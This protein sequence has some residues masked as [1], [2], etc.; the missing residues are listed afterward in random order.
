MDLKLRPFVEDFAL[1]RA[2]ALQVRGEI[3]SGRYEVVIDDRRVQLLVHSVHTDSEG[4]FALLPSGQ[5]IEL[6]QERLSLTAQMLGDELIGAELSLVS[7][8]GV[9]GARP[10]RELAVFFDLRGV[11]DGQGVV[12]AASEPPVLN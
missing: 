11:V 8:A 1:G 2:R 7:S 12:R 10:V 4:D 6:G 3:V 5:N 9:L